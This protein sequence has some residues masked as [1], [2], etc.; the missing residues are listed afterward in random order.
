MLDMIHLVSDEELRLTLRRLH[1]KIVP[2]GK[3]ILRA[4]VPSRKPVPWL[5]R[6]EEWRLKALHLTPHFR[7]VDEVAGLLSKAGFAVELKEPT[8]LNREETW[9]ICRRSGG[10]H[11]LE[12]E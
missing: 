10:G 5:R 9:F 8:A 2:G 1:E 3:L 4:T 7:S 11:L 12:M 6:V